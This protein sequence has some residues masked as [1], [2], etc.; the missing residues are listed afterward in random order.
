MSWPHHSNVVNE[1]LRKCPLLPQM[2]LLG[3]GASPDVDS[4]SWKPHLPQ[5][6]T[7]T[8]LYCLS[9]AADVTTQSK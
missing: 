5:L 1:V 8:D 6:T 7:Q 4:Q 3:Y 2:A 9:V